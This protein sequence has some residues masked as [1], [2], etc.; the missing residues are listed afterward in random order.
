[1]ADAGPPRFVSTRDERPEPKLY[2]LDD[3]VLLGWAPPDEAGGLPGM[4]VPT[5]IPTLSKAE[6][7]RWRGLSYKEVCFELLSLF[8]DD[9]SSV[10]TS[11]ELRS[12]VLD[13]ECKLVPVVSLDSPSSA[14][15]VHVAELWHGPTL[16][17]KDLSICIFIC[18]DLGRHRE[19]GDR[20]RAHHGMHPHLRHGALSFTGHFVCDSGAR[21]ADGEAR[22]APQ[23]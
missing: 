5:A 21:V 1:M 17:F 13:S 2:T 4:F 10:I 9:E 7:Q 19:R 12:L 15:K 23:H 8:R 20:R 6:L 11:D 16:A 22:G 18:G 3:A 14:R